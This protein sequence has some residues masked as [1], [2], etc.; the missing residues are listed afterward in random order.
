VALVYGQRTEGEP[1][2]MGVYVAAHISNGVNSS[3][4]ISTALTGFRSPAAILVRA[5]IYMFMLAIDFISK[6]E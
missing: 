1:R 6:D 5:C 3:Y 2:Y 4:D